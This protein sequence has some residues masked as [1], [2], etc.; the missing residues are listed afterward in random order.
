MVI[1]NH[2]LVFKT[3][4]LEIYQPT[5]P[6]IH[7]L[8]HY[9][10][11]TSCTL[12]FIDVAHR[13]QFVLPKHSRSR[14]LWDHLPGATPLKKTDSPFPTSYWDLG[15]VWLTLP[16]S[17]SLRESKA[18]LAPRGR[19][20]SKQRLGELAFSLCLLSLLCYHHSGRPA[21]INLQ[22]RKCPITWP[23][24]SLMEAFLNGG[25]SSQETLI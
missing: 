5:P 20:W 14:I 7:T 3:V 17:P 1:N 24:G 9:Q 25:S 21:H 23:I 11:L 16:W 10:P 13:F 8:P 18:E 6:R 22:S 15:F 4:T 19:N 2:G 12:S